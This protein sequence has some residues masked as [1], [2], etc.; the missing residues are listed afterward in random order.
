[1]MTAAIG[2]SWH[3][4]QS[5]FPP[6]SPIHGRGVFSLVYSFGEG[7]E[8]LGVCLTPVL[9]SRTP[10]CTPK[11]ESSGSTVEVRSISRTGHLMP[12]SEH[13]NLKGSQGW[14]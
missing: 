13:R 7:N 5:L 3:A 8:W 11:Q 4:L 2:L 6:E 1:M 14:M 9:W 12:R 10:S